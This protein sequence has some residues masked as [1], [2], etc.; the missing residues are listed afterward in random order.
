M[1]TAHTQ[2]QITMSDA[3][4]KGRSQWAPANLRRQLQWIP[5]TD[6][7]TYVYSDKIV[8]VQ[9]SDLKTDTLDLLPAMNAAL[10]STNAPALRGLPGMKWEKPGLLSFMHDNSMYYFSTTEGLMKRG[11]VPKNADITEI[12]EKTGHVGYV[13]EGNLMVY[14]DGQTLPIA[15]PEKEGIVYGKSVHRE[16]F[17]ISKGMFWNNA[18]SK[19]AFYRMDESMVTQYPIYVLDSMPAVA[20]EIRYPFAG[21]ASHHVTIGVFDL[22]RN[23]TVYL[24]TGEPAEQ[25]LTNV[26]WTADDRYILVAVVNF[27][28][29]HIWFK[30]FDAVSGE[31]VKVLFE[32]TNE[33]WAEPENEAIN[34]PGNTDQ[35]IWQSERD[36]FT[37]TT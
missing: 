31:L 5:E 25:Y 10:A 15:K 24:K 27:A 12:H 19:L 2:G 16:E 1:E 33:K 35:F 8:R 9:A 11:E 34:I 22:A 13:S 26:S 29:D 20:R 36:G 32:E 4:M 18:G 23:T 28:Q 21:S 30:Q 6:V 14:S 37:Y 7:F 17:G 3:L